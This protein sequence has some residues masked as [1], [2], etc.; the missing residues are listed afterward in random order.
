MTSC[1]PFTGPE[2]RWRG[3]RVRY[4]LPYVSLKAIL[5]TDGLFGEAMSTYLHEVSHMFGGD[6]SASFSHAL[7]E[8]LE[9]IFSRADSMAA[10]QRRWDGLSDT[11]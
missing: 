10:L 9:L 1:L 8:M 11:G 2:V 3:L 4:R 6:S 7:S 5:L